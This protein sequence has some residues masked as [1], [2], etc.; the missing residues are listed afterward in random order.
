MMLR[1]LPLVAALSLVSVA[2]AALADPSSRVGRISNIQGAVTLRNIA[3]GDAQQAS[4]NWPVTSDN[5]LITDSNAR[6]EFRI[7]SAAVRLDGNTDLEI[8]QLDDNHFRLR[9][10]RGSAEIRVRNPDLARDFSLDT[11]QGHILLS[12][13]SSVRIDAR[14]DTALTALT[15]QSGGLSFDGGNA[16]FGLPAGRH[17][18]V[19][20]GDLRVLESRGAY[21]TDSFDNWTASLDR[22]DAR[23]QSARYLSAET[24]GY[25]T[26]DSYGAW[27]VT[28]TYGPVW[29]PSAIAADW[30]PYRDGRWTWISP[31]GW[32]WVDN[33]PWGYAPSHYGRWV[34]YDQRWC[35]TPGALVAQPV[36]APALVGWVGGR[37]W[38]IGFS[39]GPAAAVGWFPLAPRDV[40]IP[41]YQVSPRYVQQVNNTYIVNGN[42][43][44]QNNYY[45]SG[46]NQTYQNQYVQN[47]VTVM[48][49]TQ[50]S[51]SKT[52]LVTPTALTSRQ[53]AIMHTAPMSVT[54]PP[55][56]APRGVA[57][58]FVNSGAVNSVVNGT[59]AVSAQRASTSPAPAM[60]AERAGPAL[61]QGW[62]SLPASRRSLPVMVAPA[63][64]S[65][66]NA[67]SLDRFQPRRSDIEAP[68]TA[69]FEANPVVVPNAQ[70]GTANARVFSASVDGPVLTAPVRA[71]S[72]FDDER[73]IERPSRNEQRSTMA[74]MPMMMAAPVQTVSGAPHYAGAAAIPPQAAAAPQMH[75]AAPVEARHAVEQ[76]PARQNAGER[77]ESGRASGPR[78]LR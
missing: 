2:T 72:N 10:Y 52:V 31:W 55:M 13:P 48:P 33:A 53:V 37:D 11:P 40:Y 70:S 50:F 28:S 36:W 46:N 54:V 78:Q 69:R 65:P 77:D 63:P 58:G 8:Q 20:D 59:S 76:H 9:L 49:Q 56:N 73:R 45:G 74:P 43:Q 16:R 42:V 22:Q 3:S 21:G 19:A 39:G 67:R 6:A 75:T 38:Q 57:S 15:V 12:E 47:A 1:P 66:I 17:A 71:R 34:Y 4:L 27:R 29:T 41:G 24:T 60:Q 18:E 14:S 51:V 35:W 23:S 32:T 7:G 5:E 62:S 26:L 30:A 25:E 64:A 44:V 61:S 68:R